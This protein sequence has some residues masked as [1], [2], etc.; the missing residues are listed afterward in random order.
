MQLLFALLISN[1][2][3]SFAGRL[4]GSLTLTA[5]ALFSG[6]SEVSLVNCSDVL[7]RKIPSIFNNFLYYNIMYR[8]IQ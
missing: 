3:G 8:K 4:T 6:L 5:A 7:H 2:A 1:S